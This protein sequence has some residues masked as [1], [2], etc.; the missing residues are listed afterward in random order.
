[1]NTQPLLQHNEPEPD[2]LE[3]EVETTAAFLDQLF[4]ALRENRMPD[5][6]SRC[7]T[8]ARALRHSLQGTRRLPSMGSQVT[9]NPADPPRGLAR[10]P[11]TP[12]APHG[13]GLRTSA[14][15]SED[16]SH[17]AAT[18]YAAPGWAAR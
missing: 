10:A 18:S 15:Q 8:R 6:A 7:V 9:I 2:S 1:M 12:I 14:R 13:L 17:S 16:G 3:M 4:C 11:I 5:L